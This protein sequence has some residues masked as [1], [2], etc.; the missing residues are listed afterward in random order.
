M[1]KYGD[2]I[3][4]KFKGRLSKRNYDE[5]YCC[6]YCSHHRHYWQV[7][8]QHFIYTILQLF[9]NIFTTT[10][11]DNYN[12]TTKVYFKYTNHLIKN[13]LNYFDDK[14]IL[15]NNRLLKKKTNKKRILWLVSKPD[16]KGE[17]LTLLALDH[18]GWYSK[19]DTDLTVSLNCIWQN[20][21]YDNIYL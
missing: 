20:S 2:E 6:E 15:N 4:N 10:H 14:K 18:W 9:I 3:E 21:S 7:A 11:K 16:C 19:S 1:A 17:S 5:N 13:L 8:L 12:L